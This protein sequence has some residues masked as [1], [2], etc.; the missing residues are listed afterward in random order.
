MDSGYS[1]WRP[2]IGRVCGRLGH[3]WI[4]VRD[5]V[6][7]DPLSGDRVSGIVFYRRVAAPSSLSAT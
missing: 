1:L 4:P 2:L 5:L 3:G 6:T 7:N